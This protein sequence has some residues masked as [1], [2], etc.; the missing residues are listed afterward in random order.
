[1]LR[2]WAE[3]MFWRRAKKVFSI[4][5]LFLD[6]FLT[7]IFIRRKSTSCITSTLFFDCNL[8]KIKLRQAGDF[9]GFN[10][11]Q[12]SSFIASGKN[13]SLGSKNSG[14]Y[15]IEYLACEDYELEE[16]IDLL[17]NSLSF[18]NFK[19]KISKSF[20]KIYFKEYKNKRFWLLLGSIF[21]WCTAI[22]L[23]RWV[24]EQGF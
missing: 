7:E 20:E 24:Q 11:F 2:I 17:T 9:D 14:S 5:L 12:I 15:V 3:R 13:L 18:P 6:W 16:K 10:D 19:N 21:W 4:H 22:V 8:S 23:L 1:M